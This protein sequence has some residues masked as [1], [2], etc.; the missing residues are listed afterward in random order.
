MADYSPK[1]VEKGRSGREEKETTGNRSEAESHKER[2]IRE[3][4][5]GFLEGVSEVV[6]NA[7]VAEVSEGDVSENVKEQKKSAPAAGMKSS[8]AATAAT[9]ESEAPP[10]IEIMRIQIATQV[11]NEIRQLEKEAAKMLKNPSSFSAF[12]LNGMVSKIRELKEILAGLAYATVETM[13]GWW[14]KFVKGIS[15]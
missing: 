12:K 8:G 13:K 4:S 6:E 7:E 5:R 11:K 3:T 1:N 14:T 2:E 15:S 9:S 10:S